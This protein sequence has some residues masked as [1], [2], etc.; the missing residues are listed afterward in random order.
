MKNRAFIVTLVFA[1]VLSFGLAPASHAIVHPLIVALP[2]AA[3]FGAAGV[4]VK[5]HKANQNNH[6][7]NTAAEKETVPTPRPHFTGFAAP[8]AV[9]K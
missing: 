6:D 3:A 4:G 5:V 8:S 9:S 2:L 7:Q 1:L